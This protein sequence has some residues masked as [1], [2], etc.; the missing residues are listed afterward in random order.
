MRTRNK[1]YYRKFDYMVNVEKELK[2]AISKRD[3]LDYRIDPVEYLEIDGKVQGLERH[4]EI[5]DESLR[6]WK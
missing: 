3:M 1:E 4:A 6:G 2:V 5:L